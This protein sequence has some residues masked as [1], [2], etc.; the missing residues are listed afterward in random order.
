MKSEQTSFVFF[1]SGPVAAENLSQLTEHFLIEAIITKPSTEHEIRSLVT[2]TPI[3]TV[4][5]K[6]ELDQLFKEKTF[7]SP[8]GVLIDFGI[9]VSSHVIHAFKKGIVN[10]HFSLLPQWRGADPIT[11]SILS[12]Q[13]STGVS[14]MLLVEKMD[15]GPILAQSVLS[16]T[17]RETTPDLTRSLIQLST[18]L[19]KNNLTPYVDGSLLPREQ[20]DSN[21]SYSRKLTKA[22][23]NIDWNKPAEQIER[24]IRAFIDW[25]KSYTNLGLVDVTITRAH[26]C[27][28]APSN[29]TPGTIMVSEDKKHFSVICGSGSLCID[30]LK[31]SGKKEMS[32]SA[33]LAGYANRINV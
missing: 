5:D 33:F 2:S 9:I 23:G 26:V 3:Y 7:S 32:C 11:F 16:M 18:T 30:T 29:R 14:L 12:G 10:S 17:G 28:N 13:D 22:D 19:I 27:E 25:P 31:P 20:K 24:E 1:G 8:V 21:I 15:E 4:T 6:Q